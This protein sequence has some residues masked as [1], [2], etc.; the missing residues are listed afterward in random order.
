MVTARVVLG[1]SMFTQPKRVIGDDS[2]TAATSE[3]SGAPQRPTLVPDWNRDVKM[4]VR[5]STLK[6]SATAVTVTVAVLWPTFLARLSTTNAIT[7][8]TLSGG[9]P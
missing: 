1:Q 5:F 7:G 6:P 3:G 9:V 8:A 4:G 2:E